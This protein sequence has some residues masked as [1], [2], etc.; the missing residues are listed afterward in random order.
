[1]AK[2]LL[3][4]ADGIAYRAGFAQ[5]KSKYLVTDAACAI[6]VGRFDSAKE[7]K[8]FD[9][10]FVWSRK[11][12]KPEEEAL[13]LASVILRDI[14]ERYPEHEPRLFLSPSVGNFRDRI[15]TRAK[16]KGNRDSAA[17]P[18][19]FKA[20]RQYLVDKYEAQEAVAQE[21]DD[22]LGIAMTEHPGSICVSFDKDLLQIPGT[23]YD[24]VKKEE[25]QISVRD[26]W[27]N[28]WRQVLSGDPVDN[29]PGIEGIGPVGAGKILEGANGN[30]ECWKRCVTAYTEKYGEDGEIFA[31]ETAQ[32]VWV[33]RARDSGFKVP[34]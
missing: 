20:I 18:V 12:V 21:A 32:L 15:A 24:W 28:F 6:V 13:M 2:L 23:H 34:A 25:K 7:T 5:E 17:R 16:Y 3:I 1:M 9:A 11:D 19:H 27:L 29:V 26:G 8:G 31:L 22:E 33:N 10:E 14:R 4:D 30:K